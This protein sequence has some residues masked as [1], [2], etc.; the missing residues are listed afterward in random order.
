MMIR[1]LLVAS[2]LLWMLCYTA[3][4]F[5]T[6]SIEAYAAGK[7]AYEEAHNKGY[8]I[9]EVLVIVDFTL[10]SN[11][12]RLTVYKH[13]FDWPGM[14]QVLH[15]KVAHGENTGGLYALNFS[16][17]VGSHMSSKGTFI[18]AE[19]YIGKYGYSLRLDGVD[20]GVNSN[21]RRRNIVVHG[22]S[23]VNDENAGR[24][25]GCFTVDI[26]H[27]TSLINLIKGGAVIFVYTGNEDD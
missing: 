6:V 7:A 14:R 25:W 16:N 23:Y 10:P 20:V 5:A 3:V 18:T 26:R 15:A 21:A 13:E 9:K 27:S 17:E 1:G 8:T 24:S 4:A 11:V 22:S 2:I 19:T 12:N